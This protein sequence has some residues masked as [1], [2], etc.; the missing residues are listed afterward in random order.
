ME[1]KSYKLMIPGPVEVSEEVLHAMGSQVQAHYGPA[2]TAFYNET[3]GLLKKV[4]NTSGDVFL[5]VGSG[6]VAIDACV[7]SA[8]STGE[9]IIIGN[10]GFFGDRLVSVAQAYGLNVIEVK[11]EWGK[12]LEPN[13]FQS[14]LRQNPNAKAV[15]VVHLETSTTI[16]NPIEEIGPM[17]RTHGGIFIV[18]AVSSLGGVPFEMD[19]WCIDFCASAVQKCLGAPPGLGPVAVNARGWEAID[20][21]PQ[22][23]HGWYSDLR[24]WRKY[25][26]EWG[27]WHPSPITMATSNVVAL[28]AA[29]EQLMQEG[30]ETRLARYKSLALRLRGGLRRLGYR[31][32][33][34]DE[35]MTPVLTAAYC[36]EG[37]SSHEIVAYLSDQYHIKISGGLG[38]LKEKMFRVGTMSPLVSKDDIDLLLTALEKFQK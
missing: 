26:I 10:N 1:S 36:P 35:E 18:D 14:A 38:A 9:K 5:M 17:V 20:R 27:D 37:V 3:L 15:A 13:D 4:F 22:K 29:L 21:N 32:F 6:T 7:G 25:A 31:L 34:P 24:T 28:H 16:L 23:N 12:R 2:W 11:A 33:T 8:L 19:R 30:I